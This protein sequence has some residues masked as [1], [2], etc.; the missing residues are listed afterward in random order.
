VGTPV[1][2]NGTTFTH[3]TKVTFGGVDA[4]SFQ[5]ITDSEVKA[6]VPASAKTGHIAITTPG[7][8]G[9]SKGIFTVTH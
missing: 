3:A 4:T 1:P 5:V 8:T 2:I 6:L 9:A 7:G